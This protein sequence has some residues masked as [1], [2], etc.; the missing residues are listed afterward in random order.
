[1]VKRWLSYLQQMFPWY[2]NWPLSFIAFFA[3]YYMAEAIIGQLKPSFEINLLFG[4]LTYGLFW[5]FL[6]VLDELKDYEIDKKL[7]RDRPL[8]TGVVTIKDLESLALLI[9]FLMIV[10]NAFLAWIN[11]LYFIISLVYCLLMFKFFFYPKISK[12][13]ILAVISH[14]PVIIVLQFYILS[15]IFQQYGY[16]VFDLNIVLMMFMFWFPWLNWEVARKIRAPEQE[17]DY[18]TYSQIFGLKGASAIILGLSTIVVGLLWHLILEFELSIIMGLVTSLSYLYFVFRVVLF[19][20]NPVSKNAI[21][22]QAAE[23]FL[24]GFYASVFLVLIMG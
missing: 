21:L 14:N 1:M 11:I 23:I 8:I 13:L 10:F 2:K 19:L 20:V 4:A 6:R 18:E 24:I 5:L 9:V 22:K 17:D 15:F 3:T 12:S 16:G 7:F